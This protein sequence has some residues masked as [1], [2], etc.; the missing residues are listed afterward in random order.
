MPTLTEILDAYK[1][2]ESTRPK[3]AYLNKISYR[4]G[5]RSGVWVDNGSPTWEQIITERNF[6]EAKINKLTELIN[7]FKL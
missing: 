3:L 6:L 4:Y 1:E 5:S 7:N 2:L